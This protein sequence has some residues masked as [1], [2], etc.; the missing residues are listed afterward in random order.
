MLLTFILLIFKAGTCF[1][2]DNLEDGIGLISMY[3]FLKNLI[4]FLITSLATCDLYNPS[5]SFKNF[6]Q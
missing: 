1:L 5:F 3:F 6:S 4:L 2:I